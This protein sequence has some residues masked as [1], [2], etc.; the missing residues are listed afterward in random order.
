MTGAAKG[1]AGPQT[2]P[3]GRAGPGSEKGESKC[4]PI[5]YTRSFVLLF[6]GALV[7]FLSRDFFS[8]LCIDLFQ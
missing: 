7:F 4:L 2:E 5:L 8:P 3:R 6:K 1:R